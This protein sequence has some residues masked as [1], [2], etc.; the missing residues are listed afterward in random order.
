MIRTTAMREEHS[1]TQQ[2]MTERIDAD[3]ADGDVSDGFTE[4][5]I[6]GKDIKVPATRIGDTTVVVLGRWLRFASVK[7]EMF[8]GGD[9]VGDPESF[10]R[11]LKARGLRAHVFTFSQK[12]PE[13]EARYDY[14]VE[15]DN[16]AVIPTTDYNTWWER[17]PQETRKNIRRAEKRGVTVRTVDVDD[18]FVRGVTEIY[19]ESRIRQG[20]PFY[21]YGKDFETI[22]R[23]L[24]TFDGTSEF[25]GAYKDDEL[26]G[27]VKLIH[28]GKISSIMHI[29][30]K[31]AHFDKR[32]TNALLAESVALCSRKGCTYL[33]YGNYTYGR[34]SNSSLAEFKRR[35]GFEKLM[36]PTYYIPLTLTGRV[37]VALRL[38]R[39]VIGILPPW[40]TSTLLVA[41]EKVL[42]VMVSLRGS[43][44]TAGQK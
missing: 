5:R 30:S 3:R 1:V 4:V 43:R 31:N 10:L 19:N 17:L 41:R 6:R 8:L 28:M 27:F 34:K 23:E 24:T 29:V 36:I 20:K 39:G 18:E 14:C 25:L 37:I 11:E 38:Y 16:L 12:P 32:P 7:D 13:V 35:N 2:N 15:W 22:K 42:Q 21:H 9:L 26:I 33:V 40:L 44:V